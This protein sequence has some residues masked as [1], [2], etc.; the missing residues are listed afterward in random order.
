[1]LKAGLVGKFLLQN[2]GHG[3]SAARES[4]ARRRV[5]FCDLRKAAARRGGD[6]FF[7]SGL[8]A[9]SGQG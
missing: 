1:M 8:I 2:Q 9:V 5:A 6:G 7:G 3:G 4:G